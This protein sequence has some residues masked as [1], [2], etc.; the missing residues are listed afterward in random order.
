MTA[1]PPLD[2]SGSLRDAWPPL[3][4]RLSWKD[5]VIQPRVDRS[6]GLP[7]VFAPGVPNSERVEAKPPPTGM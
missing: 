6:A 1:V 7:W 3:P 4:P 2:D 5:K